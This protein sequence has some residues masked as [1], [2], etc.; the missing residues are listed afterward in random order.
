MN[1]YIFLI[2]I[3]TGF[4]SLLTTLTLICIILFPRTGISNKLIRQLFD[5]IRALDTQQIGQD[6]TPLLNEKIVDF[7]G[8][9]TNQI[10]MASM[11]MSGSFAETLKVKA[12][13]QILMMIP[14]LKEEA[15]ARGEKFLQKELKNNWK[16]AIFKYGLL[17]AL[18]GGILGTIF[19]FLGV[20]LVSNFR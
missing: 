20:L 8:A 3:I 1:S 6:L 9:L 13:E 15:A 16:I 19:G 7:L 17:I 18:L 11:I 4:V 12:R 5:Q 10:P 2:P 14:E